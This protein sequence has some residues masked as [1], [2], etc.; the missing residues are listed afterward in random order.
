MAEKTRFDKI[1]IKIKNNPAL[2]VIIALGVIVI[3]LS[4]FTNAARNLLSLISKEKE[5]ANITGTWKTQALTN[6]FNPK[7]KS[8]FTFEFDAKGTTLLGTITQ[9][10]LWNNDSYKWG[11]LGGKI[12]GNNISFY[13]QQ[14]SW[15]GTEKKVYK[16][17]FYGTVSN[18]EI[19]FIQ[20]SD[21]QGGFIPQK[22]VAKKVE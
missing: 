3:A 11:I 8:T 4:T 1:F 5:S 10:T 22:F 2:A 9:T 16:D 7:Q 15:W 12:E 20:S 6:Q 17:L 18:G 21:R 14:T 13:N 19:E